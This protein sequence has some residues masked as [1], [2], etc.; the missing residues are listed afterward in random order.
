MTPLLFAARNGNLGW[1]LDHLGRDLDRRI[2]N[3]YRMFA[4]LVRPAV[5]LAFGGIVAFLC[6]SLFMP[7]ITLLGDLS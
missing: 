4:E 2:A 5:V 1:A 3:R 6:V 7:L